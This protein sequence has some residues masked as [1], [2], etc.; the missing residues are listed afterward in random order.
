MARYMVFD[1]DPDMDKS[2]LDLPDRELNGEELIGVLDAADLLQ[3]DSDELDVDAFDCPAGGVG[4]SVFDA[5]GDLVC[6]VLPEGTEPS[7]VETPEGEG[8]EPGEDPPDDALEGRIL[9]AED[10]HEV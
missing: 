5:Q 10:F 4:Y 1:A 3:T 6:D 2:P 7:D 9:E 8:A